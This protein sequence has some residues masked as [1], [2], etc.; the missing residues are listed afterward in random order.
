MQNQYYSVGAMTT[1]N[2]ASY[3][4]EFVD[5]YGQ[6]F[7]FGMSFES[8]YGSPPDDL[9]PYYQSEP[10][11]RH[12]SSDG[13]SY[14]H[15]IPPSPS[16]AA[17]SY[18]TPP[19]L[20]YHSPSPQFAP[21]PQFGSFGAMEDSYMP[22]S[23]AS[24]QSFSQENTAIPPTSAPRA[25]EVH[26]CLAPNCQAKPFKR[27]A[28]LERHY[29]HKH[30]RDK[31]GYHCDYTKCPRHQDPFFRLDHFR[32]HLRDYHKE[33]I[34]KRGVEPPKEFYHTHN[35]SSRWWRCSR[36]LRRVVVDERG[37]DCP[38]CKT[39]CPQAGVEF[40]MR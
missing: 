13:S 9:Q 5:G 6:E 27:R 18:G 36:C 39:R 29:Q 16:L 12:D 28:D 21:S 2:G 32:D 24:P 23:S 40:R 15:S 7:D 35:V 37:Y 8:S 1:Y 34:E 10:L 38:D 25:S 26:C 11:I 4:D 19:S 30:K 22:A 31:D 3:N 14:Q 33:P 17:A 20:F